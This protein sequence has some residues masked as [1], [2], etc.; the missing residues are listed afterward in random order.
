MLTN[1]DLELLKKK[2][3][4]NIEEVLKKIDEGYPIQYLIGN[5]NFYG[6]N[7]NVDKRAL[8]PRFETELLTKKTI[9]L[10]KENIVNPKIIDICTGSGCIA[11]VL[12][13][14]LNVSVDALD[15]SSDALELAQINTKENNAHINFINEDIKNFNSDKKYNVL[16]SNPPY[17]RLDEEVDPKTKYEPQNALF[18]NDNGLEFYKIIL[19]K[20]KD[21]LE[22]NNIIAFEIGCTQ[23]E[24]ILSLAKYYYPDS[25][26]Y[27]EQDLAGLDRYIFIINKK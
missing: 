10:I 3:P 7:I 14:E 9:D 25:I 20:S 8:I 1:N 19:D 27:C 23:K 18:A 2:Y 6:Y 13:K 22:D 16:I 15:I 24:D 12:S 11:I 17:V 26:S 21:L 4:N 5:V